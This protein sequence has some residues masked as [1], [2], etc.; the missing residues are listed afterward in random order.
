MRGGF[1]GRAVDFEVNW[2]FVVRILCHE[3]CFLG[4][5]GGLGAELGFMVKILH[6]ERRFWGRV[7]VF[8]ARW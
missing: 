4:K 2:W 3:V 1:R 6:R 7:A 8:E 5:E